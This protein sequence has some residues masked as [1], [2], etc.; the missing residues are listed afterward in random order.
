ML[1][2]YLNLEGGDDVDETG[3]ILSCH[4]LIF[5]QGGQFDKQITATLQYKYTYL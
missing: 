2:P 3:N 1:S 4:A 5:K